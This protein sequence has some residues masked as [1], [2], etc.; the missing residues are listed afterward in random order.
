RKGLSRVAR[1]MFPQRRGWIS[2]QIAAI[3][4][5]LALL[6]VLVAAVIDRPA[7]SRK[8][9][10]PKPLVVYC[11]ASNKSVLEAVRADYER[12]F[13]VPLQIQYGASQT[14]LA[15]LEVAGAGDLYLPADDSYLALARERKLLADEYPLA[16]M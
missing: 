1:T 13:G 4:A 10:S 7:S 11:A 8:E 14:L 15:A 6:A 2:R 9:G 5:S 3:L 12:E 16:A